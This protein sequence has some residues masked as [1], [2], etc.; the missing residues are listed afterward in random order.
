MPSIQK[1][2]LLGAGGVLLARSEREVEAPAHGEAKAHQ[3]V[4]AGVSRGGGSAKRGDATTSQGKQEGSATRGH[5]TTRWR[6]KRQLCIKR[7]RRDEKQCDNQPGKWEATARQEVLTHRERDRG[8]ATIA[9]TIT[10]QGKQEVLAHKNKS[11]T[12]GSA[13]AVEATAT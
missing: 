2:S 8:G 12:C 7:L 4:A 11:S 6:I 5:T 10:S 1:K 9:G 3:E 13:A